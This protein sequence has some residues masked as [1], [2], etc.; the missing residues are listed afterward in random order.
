MTIQ[1]TFD[2]VTVSVPRFFAV[3]WV[4]QFQRQHG[5]LFVAGTVVVMHDALTGTK[6]QRLRDINGSAD[7]EAA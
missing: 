7:C 1:V 4:H 5:Y 3:T 6:H 2:E